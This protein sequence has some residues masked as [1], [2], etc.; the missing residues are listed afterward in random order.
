[1]RLVTYLEDGTFHSGAMVIKNGMEYVIDLQSYNSSIPSRLIDILE[2]G[3][4][5]LKLILDVINNSDSQEWK[6]IKDITLAPPIP[7]PS[8]IICLGLN[9]K[10]HSPN[11]ITK[12]PEFPTIFAKYTNT[13]IGS[14]SQ[15]ILPA[16]SNQI[17]YEAEM[18]FIIGKRGKH[19]PVSDALEFVAGYT[20]FNDVSAR[21]IQTRTSQWLQGKTFDTFGPMGPCLVTLDEIEDIGN[22]D[23]SLVLN[24]QIMQKSNTKNLIFSVQEIVSFL[25]EI[26]TLEVGDVISTGTPGGVGVLQNPPIFLNEGD[27]VEVHLGGVG[28]LINTVSK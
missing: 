20:A 8:K 13:L 10:D 27:I 16:T 15:I 18:A 19:I 9:Y 12:K 6:E 1:M 7:S 23:I 28:R 5:G 11:D 3:P 21:D 14:G 2:L 22:L 17:D 26:M 25:S 24:G 4:N